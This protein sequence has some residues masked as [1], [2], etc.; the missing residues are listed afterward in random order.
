MFSPSFRM[1]MSIPES[2]KLSWTRILLTLIC[3]LEKINAN[4]DL[5]VRQSPAC[6]LGLPPVVEAKHDGE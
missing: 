4:I 3:L 6:F 1:A 2:V 5:G